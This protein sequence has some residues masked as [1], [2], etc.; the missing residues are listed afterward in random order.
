MASANKGATDS[1]KML[2]SFFS[3]GNGMVFVITKLFTGASLIN[4]TARPQSTP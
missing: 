2:S 4:C 3:G 1:T